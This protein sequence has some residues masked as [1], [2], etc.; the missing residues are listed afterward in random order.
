[1]HDRHECRVSWEHTF[2]SFLPIFLFKL[3]ILAWA[4]CFYKSRLS[5]Y[6]NFF[7]FFLSFLLA[8]GT[9]G[10]Q[11]KKRMNFRTRFIDKMSQTSFSCV[12]FLHMK[13]SLDFMQISSTIFVVHCS[14]YSIS[15]YFG[16]KAPTKHR[17]R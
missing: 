2:H 17:S 10:C 9:W 4:N 1:M 12:E 11:R 8:T 15:P 3:R 16:N 13:R 14:V 5:H 6:Y 7:F